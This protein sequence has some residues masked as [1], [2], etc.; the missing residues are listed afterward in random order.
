MPDSSAG[1][2]RTRSRCRPGGVKA[3][4]SISLAQVASSTSSSSWYLLTGTLNRFGDGTAEQLSEFRSGG[5]SPG[6][7]GQRR[8]PRWRLW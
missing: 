6:G 4:L 7:G 3:L 8:A 2:L 5:R 1:N